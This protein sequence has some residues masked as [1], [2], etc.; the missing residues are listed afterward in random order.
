MS[1]TGGTNTA[2][3]EPSQLELRLLK[4]E[5]KEYCPY[6]YGRG[7]VS[8]GAGIISYFICTHKKEKETE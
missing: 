8:N 4:L 2:N 6:C 1:T 3:D 7:Y 5:D